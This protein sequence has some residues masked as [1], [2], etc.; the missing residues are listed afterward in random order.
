MA[1]QKP[2]VLRETPPLTWDHDPYGGVDVSTMRELLK[3]TPAERF[4]WAVESSNNVAK[5]VEQARRSLRRK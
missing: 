5:L 1:E 4:H 2:D 3:M